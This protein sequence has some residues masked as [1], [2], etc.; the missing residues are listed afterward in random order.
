M[1]EVFV[2]WKKYCS[3]KP[4]SVIEEDKNYYH[5]QS[6]QMDF[7]L[8]ELSDCSDGEPEIVTRQPC[9]LNSSESEQKETSFRDNLPVSK[10]K[11]ILLLVSITTLNILSESISTIATLSSNRTNGDVLV[12]PEKLTRRNVW[13]Q[14]T[15]LKFKNP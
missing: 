8:S 11:L 5:D 15:I 2:V 1:E 3:S 4:S 10:K 12:V 13:L 6:A 9:K 7:E 14:W